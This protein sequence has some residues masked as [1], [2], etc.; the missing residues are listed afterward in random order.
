[1]STFYGIWCKDAKR[2]K[3]DW[4]REQDADGGSGLIAFPSRAAAQR[5]AA[6]MYGYA[7]YGAAKRDDWCE[8][9]PLNV[10]P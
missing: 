9:R 1:M 5:R 7:T 4:L 2:D 3:G 8:V 10:K 6:R